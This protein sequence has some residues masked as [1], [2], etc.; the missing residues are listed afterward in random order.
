MKSYVCVTLKFGRQILCQVGND[1]HRG[2]AGFTQ[3][4]DVHVHQEWYIIT[5]ISLAKFN[6]ILFKILI[7]FCLR[8]YFLLERKPSFNNRT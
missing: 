7:K 3:V 6:R 2:S 8:L 1:L 5:K 4:S